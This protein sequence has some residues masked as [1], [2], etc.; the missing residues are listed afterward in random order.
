[1]VVGNAVFPE[2][3]LPPGPI[4]H[5]LQV[6]LVSDDFEPRLVTGQIWLPSGSGRSTPYSQGRRGTSPARCRSGSTPPPSPSRPAR[7]RSWP[8]PGS[9]STTKVTCS[10]RRS[11]ERASCRQPETPL[12]EPNAVE[13]DFVLSKAFR[14]VEQFASRAVRFGPKDHAESHPVMLN[15]TLNG[16]GS[17][18]H[19]ILVKK[20]A[21]LPTG[22]MSY[23]PA[24]SAKELDKARDALGACFYRRNAQGHLRRNVDGT[25]QV[26]LD[27][28][29]GKPIEQFKWDLKKLAEVGSALFNLIFLQVNTEHGKMTAKAWVDALN[30]VLADTAVIQVA[31]TTPANYVFPWGLV[32]EHP[33]FD[34]SSYKFCK[35]VKE[36]WGPTSGPRVDPLNRTRCPYHDEPWHRKNILCP[37]GFWGLKHVIEQPP[38]E[39]TEQRAEG[40]E[41]DRTMRI[42]PPIPLGVAVSLDQ[43]FDRELLDA[44]LD[45]LHRLS[46]FAFQPPAAD[47][48]D[49]VCT[50]F[51]APRL[52]YY[53]LCHDEWDAVQDDAYLGVGPATTTMRTGSTRSAW[54][55]GCGIHP[56]PG[57]TAARW[58]SST[59]ATPPTSGRARF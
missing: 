46:P 42:K 16:D 31:R 5:D 48:W 54:W 19:R 37:Y 21:A 52:V 58:S 39:L 18:K 10:S 41:V 6:V 33:L 32:Y 12:T 22:W 44:H 7:A 36:D 38:S 59:G 4:G 28:Y 55:P 35:V 40:D 30:R 3:A 23:D 53:F 11:S 27:R 9:A 8:G 45:W 14:N 29:N 47:D 17:G 57:A 25:P 2:D 20:Q 56:S 50:M 51:D 24:N 34:P 1:M 13:V 49:Q 26:G 15:L 43:N